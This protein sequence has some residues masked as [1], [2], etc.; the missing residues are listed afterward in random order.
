M[1]LVEHSTYN[2]A[3]LKRRL[4]ETDLKAR[5]CELC[6]QGEIWNGRRI[7][8][9]LDHINGVRDDNR[10]EN[11]RIVCPNCAA[12]LDTHCGRNA[13]L[14]IKEARCGVCREHFEVRYSRQRFCS[15]QCAGKG[16]RNPQRGVPKLSRRKVAR[17]PRDQLVAEVEA[18]GFSAVGRKY[19]VSDNA[20]RKWLIWY[21]R[22]AV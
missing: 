13:R 20:I 11:L 5:V 16:K 17:P 19:G 7:A 2:R 1:I 18:L 8:L 6:G 14:P 9:I 10:L 15:I 3:D 12:G 4:F 21:D 22:E